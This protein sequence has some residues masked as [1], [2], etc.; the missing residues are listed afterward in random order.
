[1]GDTLET[2][3]SETFVIVEYV[4]SIGVR[5][6]AVCVGETFVLDP[7]STYTPLPFIVDG[8]APTPLQDAVAHSLATLPPPVW[9]Y[10]SGPTPLGQLAPYLEGCET[11]SK[12]DVLSHTLAAEGLIVDFGTGMT[13]FGFVLQGLL[14]CAGISALGL[15]FWHPMPLLGSWQAQWLSLLNYFDREEMRT[16]LAGTSLGKNAVKGQKRVFLFSEQFGEGGLFYLVLST[17]S[18]KVQVGGDYI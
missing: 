4:V 15:C 12:N 9:Y 13:L 2:D 1:L 11:T 3:I 16:T 7:S 8:D 6:Q 17:E 5:K 10:L 14:I 18:G